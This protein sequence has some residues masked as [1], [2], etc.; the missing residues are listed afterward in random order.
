[1][2]PVGV[3]PS[4]ISEPFVPSGCYQAT[5]WETRGILGKESGNPGSA[6]SSMVKPK[7]NP[8]PLSSHPAPYS[9]HPVPSG[10]RAFLT[11][12]VTYLFLWLFLRALKPCRLRD[13]TFKIIHLNVHR[14]Y[15]QM[16]LGTKPLNVFL[17]PTESPSFYLKHY[18]LRSILL[19]EKCI[20]LFRIPKPLGRC[21]SWINQQ[22]FECCPSFTC[23][24]IIDL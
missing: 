24:I 11:K 1:M 13:Y 21:V 12:K 22:S 7:E 14:S 5:F 2:R 15:W 8:C 4:L 18:S 16:I 17:S 9:L 19:K 23:P 20:G 10:C 3:K 6:F